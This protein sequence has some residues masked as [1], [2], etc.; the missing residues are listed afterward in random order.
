MKETVTVIPGFTRDTK[1]DDRPAVCVF[2]EENTGKTRFI[3]TAPHEEGLLG[4]LA[5]DKN[6]KRSIEEWK[7]GDSHGRNIIVN[8]K[9]FMTDKDALKLAVKDC[10]V[11]EDLKLILKTYGDMYQRILEAAV[12]LADDPNVESIG[13]DNGSLLFDMILFSHFGRRNQIE[14]FQRG[15]PNQDMI[16]F[17]NA[18][19]FKNFVLVCRASEIWKDTGET[20]SQGRKKQ[21]PT[22][23]LKPDGFGKLGYFMTAVCELTARR[24][25]PKDGRLDEKYRVVVKT[26]KGNTLLEGWDL[27]EYGVSGEN[28]TWENLLT[29]LGISA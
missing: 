1:P 24:K 6:C 2:G 4:V 27:H 3:C 12:R 19:R 11:A 21:S 25:M 5:L 20:D 16:D 10:K 9:P 15:A 14:S 17:I 8:D 13:L 23:V 28:I 7:R 29:A 18:M 26:A 22:G